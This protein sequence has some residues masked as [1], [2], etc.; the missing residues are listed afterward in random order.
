MFEQKTIDNKSEIDEN[1]K[2]KKRPANSPLSDSVDSIAESSA[3]VTRARRAVTGSF[4]IGLVDGLSNDQPLN[5]SIRRRK[6]YKAVD[7]TTESFD[8]TRS[9]SLFTAMPVNQQS[10]FSMSQPTFMQGGSPSHFGFPL[11][12]PTPPWAMQILEDIQEL[13]LKLKSIENIEKTVNTINSKVSNLETKY[14]SLETRVTDTEKACQY[15]SNFQ[16]TAKQ[17][18][19]S[20]H[21][22]LKTLKKKCDS[23]DSKSKV[24]EKEKDELESKLD[25]IES[26]SLRTNLLFYG[27]AEQDTENCINSVKDV[28]KSILD[29]PDASQH[30]IERANRIGRKSGGKPRPILATYHYY[31]ERE[32]VR[33]KSYD[34]ADDLKKAGF[35]VGIHLTKSIRDARKPLYEPMR[36]AKQEGKRVKFVGKKLYINDTLYRNGSDN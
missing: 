4:N 28:C 2:N 15:Q 32:A 7:K 13:K 3:S 18:I 21:D 27:I 8:E 31:A 26:K 24:L 34:K 33:L 6:K 17:E 19:K 29:M 14:K 16:E 20:T 35:G 11:Q 22:E 30:L 25:D 9:P 23:L 10:P 12:P 36:Q 1:S 5:Q